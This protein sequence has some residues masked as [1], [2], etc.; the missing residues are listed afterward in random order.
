[1]LSSLLHDPLTSVSE[2]SR[3]VRNMVQAN[4]KHSAFQQQAHV[5]L[6]GF[7]LEIQYKLY[8]INVLP[9][10]MCEQNHQRKD[11]SPCHCIDPGMSL[12]HTDK[13]SVYSSK[14][15]DTYQK[16]RCLLLTVPSAHCIYDHRI[17]ALPASAATACRQRTTSTAT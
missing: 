11:N 5:F 7:G 10:R 3:F 2:G 14:L 17:R 9:Q 1:V 8:W 16:W 12:Q 13:P 4:K 15:G 6:D